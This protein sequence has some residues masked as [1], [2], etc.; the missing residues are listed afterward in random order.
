MTLSLSLFLLSSFTH[1]LREITRRLRQIWSASP[2]NSRR[3]EEGI[4]KIRSFRNNPESPSTRISLKRIDRHSNLAHFTP[5]QPKNRKIHCGKQLAV[6]SIYAH[7]F[8]SRLLSSNFR[9]AEAILGAKPILE[10]I[11][12]SRTA[13]HATVRAIDSRWKYGHVSRADTNVTRLP[14][15]CRLEK[16][17]ASPANFALIVRGEGKE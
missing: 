5:L 16:L 3:G 6:P 11:F 17:E 2:I 8:L 7:E 4:G 10:T 9:P 13:F 12:P 15:L 1:A 14:K